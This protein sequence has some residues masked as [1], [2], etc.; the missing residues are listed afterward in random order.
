MVPAQIF[1]S[2]EDLRADRP[3]RTNFRAQFRT[4]KICHAQKTKQFKSNVEKIDE[5]VDL[6]EMLLSRRMISHL[7]L[8]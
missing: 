5:P 1:S 2:T 3:S 4:N 6:L 8:V 7:T